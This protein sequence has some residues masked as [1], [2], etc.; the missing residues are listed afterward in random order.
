MNVPAITLSYVHTFK[1]VKVMLVSMGLLFG[2]AGV[3][4]CNTG[5]APP[6]STPAQVL[7]RNYTTDIIACAAT[8]GFPGA[9]DEASDLRCRAK[10]NCTYGVG[11]CT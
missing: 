4:H 2:M 6:A 3:A 8:A 5:C 11:P 7:E 1:A 9:Y 10:V